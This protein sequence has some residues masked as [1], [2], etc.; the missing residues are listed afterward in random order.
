MNGKKLEGSGRG[1]F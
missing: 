1:L